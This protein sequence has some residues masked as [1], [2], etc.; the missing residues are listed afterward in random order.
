MKL[1]IHAPNVHQGGGQTLLTS[2]IL[3][4]E[5]P[6]IIFVD[7]RYK[8]PRIQNNQMEIFRINPDIKSR[9]KAEFCLKRIS[10]SD[11]IVICFGNLPPLIKNPGRVFVYL[12][13]QY[14]CNNSSLVKFSI[15]VKLRILLERIW[16]KLFLRNAKI[17]VQGSTMKRNVDTFF[18]HNSLIMP[19]F[20]AHNS[21]ITELEKNYQYDY[22]YVASDEPHKNHL[23]LLNAWILLAENN[24]Y[25]SLMLTID[26][27]K[28]SALSRNILE[29]IRTFKLNVKGQIV[30]SNQ[31]QNLYR[32]SRALIY[33]SLFESFGLP[34]LEAKDNGLKIIASERDY[35]RDTIVP[36]YTFDPDSELSIARAVMRHMGKESATSI[37]DDA[38][39]FI[40]KIKNINL[41]I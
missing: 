20:N 34:L 29:K 6:A 38:R 5:Q 8:L 39:T 30:S 31:I 16:L 25:P 27:Y 32:Q 24:L 4:I 1:I 19:F 12:Q 14:L 21:S 2:L 22:L 41:K 37:P 18:G 26:L 11:D 13:N 3:A 36:D 23:K 28:D 35:V 7:S 10:C 15:I 17:I 40:K 9:L 33:P